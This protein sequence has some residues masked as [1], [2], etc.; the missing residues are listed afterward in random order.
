MNKMP[1]NCSIFSSFSL[2]FLVNKKT[3]EIGKN[4]IRQQKEHTMKT[5]KGISAPI[6]N[7]TGPHLKHPLKV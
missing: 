3:E 4:M 5:Y 2:F 6:L 1:C 7:P